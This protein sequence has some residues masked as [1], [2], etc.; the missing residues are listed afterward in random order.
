MPITDLVEPSFDSTARSRTVAAAI[1][2]AGASD[3][4]WIQP[5]SSRLVEDPEGNLATG[6]LNAFGETHNASSFDVTIDTGEALI[7]GAYLARDTTTTVTL[8]SSTNNQ[9]VYVG[10][11]D[12]VEDSVIIG[13]SGSFTSDDPKHKIWTFDTDG[14]GVTSATDQRN[15]DD[16]RVRNIDVDALTNFAGGNKF[17]DYPLHNADLEVTQNF[18]LGDQFSSYPITKSDVSFDP[19]DPF[20]GDGR[21]GSITRSANANE[22]GLIIASDYTVQSGVTMTVTG[23]WLVV[24][25]QNS[26]TIEGE[27]N[28]DG[29]GASGAAGGSSS[30]SNGTDSFTTPTQSGGSGGTQPEEANANGGSGGSGSTSTPDNVRRLVSFPD[31]VLDIIDDNLP[32]AGASGGSGGPGASA[33]QGGTD[34]NGG[35]GSSPGGAGAGGYNELSGGEALT[36]DDNGGAGGDGGGF[37]ALIA[38]DITVNGTI[39]VAGTNGSNGSTGSTTN[40]GGGGGGGGSGGL[41][42]L[43]CSSL[44]DGSATYT[45]SAGSGG[46]GASDTSANG[47]DGASGVSGAVVK[48]EQ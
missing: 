14:S 9:D 32:G 43:S 12:S 22:N 36:T 7:G 45:T 39:S 30:G 8:S 25:A 23:G 33:D 47:G 6:A 31:V 28:A 16:F 34:T 19:S 5:S 41:I 18:S 40:A 26:I 2:Y 15:L 44:T 3:G 46:T 38:P 35:N 11:E 1:R 20:Y 13:K 4:G 21:D 37:I 10:W 42:F 24:K 29:Q 27:L 17:A 48:V